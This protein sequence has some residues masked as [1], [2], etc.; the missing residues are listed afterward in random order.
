[1]DLPDDLRAIQD[2][3]KSI[4]TLKKKIRYI[5]FFLQRQCKG[6]ELTASETQRINSLPLLQQELKMLETQQEGEVTFQQQ[7]NGVDCDTFLK[8]PQQSMTFTSESEK[9]FKTMRALRKKIRFIHYHVERQEQGK[10][11][12][13]AEHAKVLSLPELESTLAQLEA[14]EAVWQQQ[15]GGRRWNKHK[16]AAAA[17]EKTESSSTEQP[18]DSAPA[19]PSSYT[20]SAPTVGAPSLPPPHAAIENLHNQISAQKRQLEE[21]QRRIENLMKTRQVGSPV[22]MSPNHGFPPAANQSNFIPS[23]Y[24]SPGGQSCGVG[25]PNAGP[26]PL[27]SPMMSP[28]MS[29]NYTLGRY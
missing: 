24:L 25:S 16:A 14:D 18:V 13:P 5:S 2:R 9:R 23:Y 28:P 7:A 20:P 11:L 4:R 27:G 29:P 10:S 12:S 8:K 6:R 17:A 1:E 21:K 22:K 19:Q 15:N 26:P 3:A